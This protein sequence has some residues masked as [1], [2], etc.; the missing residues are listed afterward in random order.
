M[1]TTPDPAV[2]AALRLLDASF[3]EADMAK[4]MAL[5][6]DWLKAFNALAP[7]QRQTLHPEIKKHMGQKRAPGAR[8]RL[9]K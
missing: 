3:E 2:A 4:A 7:D 9:A 8:G 6:G 1:P 5:F